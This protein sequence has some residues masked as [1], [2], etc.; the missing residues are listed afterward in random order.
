MQINDSLGGGACVSIV[1]D[2]SAVVTF[3]VSGDETD[4]ATVD[5]SAVGF[6]L[7]V[8]SLKHW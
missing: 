7:V 6:G 8:S 5:G 2:G 3:D 4:V 1:V